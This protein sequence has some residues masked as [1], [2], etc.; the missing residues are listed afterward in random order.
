MKVKLYLNLKFALGL[1]CPLLKDRLDDFFRIESHGLNRP[2]SSLVERFPAE[3]AFGEFRAQCKD[4]PERRRGVSR[5]LLLA[6]CDQY[7]K[8][9]FKVQ[10]L[11]FRRVC[12]RLPVGF[13]FD[14][15]SAYGNH[16]LCVLQYAG[17]GSM[18][19]FSKMPF[20]HLAEN[21]CNALALGPDNLL[22][23]IDKTP[24]QRI[25]EKGTDGALARSHKAGQHNAAG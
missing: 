14:G 24:A 7:I 10:Q 25:R 2:M 4:R 1:M 17:Q 13:R 9:R 20:A 18:F 11:G 15:S 22:I 21:G 16:C 8:R 6:S 23:Q 5:S 19:Q 12:N 3:I